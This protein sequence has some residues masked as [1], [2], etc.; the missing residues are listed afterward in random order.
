MRE[1]APQPDLSVESSSQHSQ[2]IL[3]AHTE[4]VP[5]RASQTNGAAYFSSTSWRFPEHLTNS[6]LINRTP[7]QDKTR[8]PSEDPTVGISSTYGSPPRS[9]F[10][11]GGPQKVALPS[12]FSV[13]TPLHPT[14]NSTPIPSQST[15][16]EVVEEGEEDQDDYMDEDEFN[17]WMAQQHEQESQR[18]SSPSESKIAT[19]RK[20]SVVVPRNPPIAYPFESLDEYTHNN[21]RLTPRSFVELKDEDFLKIVHIVRDTSTQDVSIRGYIFRRTREMNGLLDRKRNEVCWILHVDD[22]DP[23][24]PLTQ[25]VET[26]AVSEVVRRRNIRLTNRPFPD[27]SFRGDEKDTEETV[28]NARV[29]VCR[30]KYLCFYPTA[31]ARIAYAWCEKGL[32]RLRAEEC[33]KR[34]DNNLD[35]ESLRYAWRGTTILGGAKE[36][37]LA[38]E[39]EFLRQEA[40]SHEGK[41]SWQSLKTSTGLDYPPG[42]PMERGSVGTLLFESDLSQDTDTYSKKQTT[43]HVLPTT[44]EADQDGISVIV[45]PSVRPVHQE[46]DHGSANPLLRDIDGRATGSN[47]HDVNDALEFFDI[48]RRLGER[49]TELHYT[50][51]RSPQIIEIDAKIK[52]SSELGTF[53]KHYKGKVTS[54]YVPSPLSKMKR[55]ADDTL[56]MNSRPTKRAHLSDR[57]DRVASFRNDQN[58]FRRSLDTRSQGSEKVQARQDDFEDLGAPTQPGPLSP[59]SL[60]KSNIPTGYPSRISQSNSGKIAESLRCDTVTND[61]IDLTKPSKN[62][63]PYF[64]DEPRCRYVSGDFGFSLDGHGHAGISPAPCRPNQQMPSR[65]ARSPSLLRTTKSSRLPP[66]SRSPQADIKSLVR[67]SSKSRPSRS[68]LS[69]SLQQDPGPQIRD[70]SKAKQQRYTFGDCF[71]GAGGMSRG[72]I[73]AGLRINWAFDFNLKACQSY[74]RNFFGTPVYKVWANE[75]AAAK[76]D[77]KVDICHLSPPCQFF[78]DAHTIQGKDDDMNTASLFSIYNLLQQAKPRIVTLEQTSGLIRRHPIFFNAVINMFTSRGFSVRW[79]VMNCADFGLAQRRMRLFI[80]AS[81]YVTHPDSPLPHLFSQPTANTLPPLKK[82]SY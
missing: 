69:I 78:S 31:K 66:R 58:L 21:I 73:S 76:G 51:E 37:W 9:S 72:A 59:C 19:T 55:A 7:S 80:I 35:D 38:G 3:Q 62:V 74:E 67:P 33:D 6:P 43:S 77:Y 41:I 20:S 25:G 28:T 17:V 16:S 36:G 79:R 45:P 64:K 23:R 29:L 22:D 12:S 8:D 71:C 32:H 40:R 18:H 34:A 60:G 65:Q 82:K 75:F 48:S 56:E 46:I 1:Q 30:F 26:R 70:S 13:P 52:I 10:S 68:E 15:L 39:K 61:V 50:R 44:E 57:I 53:E 54:T 24:D 4:P 49:P 42:D 2:I 27:L 11:H 47:V 63:P 14:S 81:W 5:R